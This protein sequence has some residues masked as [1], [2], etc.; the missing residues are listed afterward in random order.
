MA[1]SRAV[2]VVVAGSAIAKPSETRFR[3]LRALA[4]NRLVLAG[5]VLAFLL[6]LMALMADL[7]APYDPV[8]LDVRNR[9][10]A[11]SSVHLFGTDRIGRDVLSRVIHG[12]RKWLLI[13]FTSMAAGLVVGTLLGVISG[14]CGGTV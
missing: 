3:G 12:S 5:L 13:A 7:I 8:A 2:P 14:Y 10:S 11:P 6:V 1:D 9:L 4:A